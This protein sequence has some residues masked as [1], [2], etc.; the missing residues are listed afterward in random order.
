MPRPLAIVIACLALACAGLAGAL[1]VSGGEGAPLTV[2]TLTGAAP[3]GPAVRDWSAVARRVEPAIAVVRARTGADA[4]TDAQG[5]AFA[6]DRD[7]WFVTNEHVVVSRDGDGAARV[8]DEIWLDYPDGRRSRARLVGR[9]RDG[10]LALLRAL[11][12][13]PAAALTLADDDSLRVGQPVATLG[14]PGGLE[15]TLSVGVVS[16]LGRALPVARGPYSINGAIQTDALVSPGSS[17]GPLVDTRGAVVGVVGQFDSSPA[18]GRSAGFAIPVATL[19]A[20]LPALR[21]GGAVRH[22]RLGVSGQTM[23]PQLAGRLGLDHTSG[24]L[25]QSVVADSPAA[26]AGLQTG[27]REI[28]FYGQS[29]RA[30]GDLIV[31]IDGEPVGSAAD[32]ADLVASHRPGDQ[33]HLTVLR[34]GSERALA[35]RIDARPTA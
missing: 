28:S 35:V 13:R 4:A 16:S 11:D 5:T 17:G 15:G 34:G 26:A 33:L 32:L 27:D 21:A 23:T 31:A 19:R 18:G 29:L 14:A 20:S 6:I 7:G 12:A 25:V 8:A 3:P 1:L 30:G 22:G 2:T 24:V 9:D 10:D